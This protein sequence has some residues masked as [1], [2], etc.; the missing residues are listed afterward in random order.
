[1]K[2]WPTEAVELSLIIGS[3]PHTRRK[4]FPNRRESLESLETQR[5]GDVF[6]KRMEEHD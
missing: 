4:M 6:F 1:M 3:L 5:K 2:C